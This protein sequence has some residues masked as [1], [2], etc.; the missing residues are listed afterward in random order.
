MRPRAGHAWTTHK[1][2]SYFMR[3]NGEWV[4]TNYAIGWPRCSKCRRPYEKNEL[5]TVFCVTCYFY[6][7]LPKGSFWEMQA[8]RLF[9]YNIGKKLLD[10]HP[11]LVT[12]PNNTLHP[13]HSETAQERPVSP[14]SDAK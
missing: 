11:A 14:A 6:K 7:V 1:G 5:T 3:A 4:K 12:P 8:H 2:Q 9:P 13:N 10:K